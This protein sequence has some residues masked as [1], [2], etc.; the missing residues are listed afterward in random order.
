MF[1]FR[2]YRR[3][4]TYCIIKWL[5]EG[6]ILVIDNR[7]LQSILEEIWALD[8]IIRYLAYKILNRS[9]AIQERIITLGTGF[10]YGHV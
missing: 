5:S 9:I 10:E 3:R 6:S 4:R 8:V 7:P 2:Y 1:I